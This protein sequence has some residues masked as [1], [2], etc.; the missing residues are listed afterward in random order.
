MILL[1]V[2]VGDEVHEVKQI[3]YAQLSLLNGDPLT[4]VGAAVADL[5]D[6]VHAAQDVVARDIA[7]LLGRHQHRERFVIRELEI[8]VDRIHP[9]DRELHRPAAVERAGVGVDM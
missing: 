3:L 1:G 6:E 5:T 9:L 8:L 4:G 7:E 2:A